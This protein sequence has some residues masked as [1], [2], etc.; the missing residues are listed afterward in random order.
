MSLLEDFINGL[1]GTS[2]EEL[3]CEIKKA[4]EDSKNSH[5]LD[6]MEF[7][8]MDLTIE[9]PIS[10]KTRFIIWWLNLKD[11]IAIRRWE[12]KH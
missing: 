3:I 8:K 11:E 2:A 6:D 9:K 12:R 5:I 7:R 10:F 4:E 1:Q